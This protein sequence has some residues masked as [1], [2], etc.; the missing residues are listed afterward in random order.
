MRRIQN[1]LSLLILPLLVFFLLS[2]KG[3]PGTPP[4][5]HPFIYEITGTAIRVDLR[6]QD[7][8]RGG[9]T[10][11]LNVSLPWTKDLMYLEPD[12]VGNPY[13]LSAQNITSAGS[14]TVSVYIDG[15]LEKT[16]TNANA[17]GFVALYGT[18]P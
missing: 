12:E 14:V 1:R 6:Y 17:F 13:Y 16:E 8:R 5:Q 15:F 9:Y 2:C 11:I 3:E 4:I 10:E 7:P 18:T